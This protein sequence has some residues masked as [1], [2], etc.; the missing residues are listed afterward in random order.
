[1]SPIQTIPDVDSYIDA[2]SLVFA[3]GSGALRT[4]R[5]CIACMRHRHRHI[6]QSR[7]FFTRCETLQCGHSRSLDRRSPC[8]PV[9]VTILEQTG[10]LRKTTAGQKAR[11]PRRVPE[12]ARGDWLWHVAVAHTLHPQRNGPYLV[13][14]LDMT[15]HAR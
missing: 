6:T 4:Q 15:K 7:H 3:F 11:T 1:M 13:T 5:K 10:R 8:S 2:S 12:Y 9:T 14:G